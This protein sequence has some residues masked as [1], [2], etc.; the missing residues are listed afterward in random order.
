MPANNHQAIQIEQITKRLQFA[1]KTEVKRKGSIAKVIG[2]EGF[3][4]YYNQLSVLHNN[5]SKKLQLVQKLIQT[6]ADGGNEESDGHCLRLYLKGLFNY[7]K[8][9]MKIT[10]LMRDLV[11]NVNDY[12]V[13][14]EDDDDDDSQC[15]EGSDEYPSSESEGE[16]E[17]LDDTD[18]Y[19]DSNDDE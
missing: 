13:Y 14:N 10:R 11:K 18:D 2:D 19:E 6:N 5:A 16:G 12:K 7:Q 4:R 8:D 15:E 17:W 3:D 9:G 1:R